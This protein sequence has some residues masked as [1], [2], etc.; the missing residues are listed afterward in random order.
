MVVS[1]SAFGC[2]ERQKKG[3]DISYFVSQVR[4]LQFIER[5]LFKYLHFRFPS[6]SARGKKWIIST[7]RDKFVTTAASRICS[8]H[9][10]DEDFR[11]INNPMN[12]EEKLRLLKKDAVPS[13]F[14]F[15]LHLKRNEPK[16]RI[17]VRRNL[18]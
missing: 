18:P 3:S 10:K 11:Q 17:G 4:N 2:Q 8:K 1:C 5:K 9:F 7:Q 12:P 14:N 16:P 6:N 13:I 15:P